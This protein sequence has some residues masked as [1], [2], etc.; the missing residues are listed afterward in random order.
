MTKRTDEELRQ[1]WREATFKPLSRRSDEIVHLDAGRRALY[2]LGRADGREAFREESRLLRLENERLTRERNEA[3]AERDVAL[4]RECAN[5]TAC[6]IGRSRI[7]DTIYA[8]EYVRRR[9]HYGHSEAHHGASYL[10]DTWADR[11]PAKQKDGRSYLDPSS[12]TEAEVDAELREMGIDPVALGE[13]AVA[14][15]AS[16]KAVEVESGGED[17]G[18]KE[19]L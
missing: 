16:A 2:D 17:D 9:G 7:R 18:A 13:R 11:M 15:V 6:R 4:A 10:A 5:G 14:F 8:A 19:L 12:M 3:R 1:V